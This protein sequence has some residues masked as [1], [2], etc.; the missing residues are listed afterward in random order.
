[1]EE[2]RGLL[3]IEDI[4]DRRRRSLRM[5]F[6]EKVSRFMLCPC[7]L[8]EAP[9]VFD[10]RNQAHR[11]KADCLPGAEENVQMGPSAK[12]EAKRISFQNAPHLAKGGFYPSRIGI[13]L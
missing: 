2:G 8:P 13:A 11:A 3:P 5:P 6:C 10:E 1:M 9:S 4:A 12:T 7:E